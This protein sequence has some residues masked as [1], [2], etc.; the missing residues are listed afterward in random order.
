MKTLFFLLA[1]T[2]LLAC[3]SKYYTYNSTYHITLYQNPN[4]RTTALANVPAG[5]PIILTIQS[6][7]LAYGKY[8]GTYG[9][10][11]LDSLKYV[12][13]SNKKAYGNPPSSSAPV[14]KKKKKSST[15]Y[16]SSSGGTVQVKGY[17]RKN[18]TYVKPHTRKA[19]TKKY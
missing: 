3:G 10:V 11:H 1:T 16:S 9:W 17:Y 18:G 4:V 7:T 6:N 2:C 19:P 8:K 14:A 5:E 12:S 13:K 15:S